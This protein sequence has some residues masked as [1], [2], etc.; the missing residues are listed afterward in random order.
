M[1]GVSFDIAT[2]HAILAGASDTG[3]LWSI[4]DALILGMILA[5]IYDLFFAQ[6][7][8]PVHLRG[9]FVGR[10][11]ADIFYFLVCGVIGAVFLYRANDG[12]LRWYLIVAG[13]LGVYGYRL[14]LGVP[15]NAVRRWIL[16]AVRTLAGLLWRTLLFS[17]L[18]CLGRIGKRIG[19]CVCSCIRRTV[20]HLHIKHRKTRKQRRKAAVSAMP[21]EDVYE[22]GCISVSDRP[23]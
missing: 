1:K 5:L 13:I 14:T 19:A 20:A 3:V 16:S 10:F 22:S 6:I 23:L 8:H 2:E 7:G 9:A 12:I 4:P 11:L 21:Q 17:P 18:R 15:L